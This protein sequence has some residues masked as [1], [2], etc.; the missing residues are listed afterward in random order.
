MTLLYTIRV[1]WIGL[2]IGLG[3]FLLSRAVVPGGT[4]TYQTNLL[5]DNY[6][7][8]PLAPKERLAG[9]AGAEQRTITGEPVYFSLFTPRSFRMAEITL[10][11]AGTAPLIELGIRRGGQTWNFE[12]QPVWHQGLEELIQSGEATLADGLVLWQRAKKYSTPAEFIAH[13]PA[14]DEIATYN[15]SLLAPFRLAGSA[16]TETERSLAV[17]LRGNYLI[18]TY[19]SGE[20]IAFS[21]TLRDLNQNKDRDDVRLT[22]YD[23]TGGVRASATLT[24]DDGQNKQVSQ[25]RLVRIESGPLPAGP[26]RL[27]FSANDDILT[28]QIQTRQSAV[29]FIN[30]IWLTENGR[31]SLSL[32]SDAVRLTAQTSAPGSRQTILFDGQPLALQETYRQ[33]SVS[34][35]DATRRAKKIVLGRD[36]VTLSVDGSLAFSEAELLNV[37]PRQFSATAFPARDQAAYVIARYE[38]QQPGRSQVTF[39]LDGAYR[40]EGKYSFMIAAPGVSPEKPL[41]IR[42]IRVRLVGPTLWHYIQ[43]K[44][45]L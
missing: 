30:H 36:D 11:Y 3:L 4:I 26:Y 41:E 9:Q 7:I 13:P 16:I 43:R 31:S 12:R 39:R 37:A 8:G 42:S 14:V 22:L 34:A 44:L 6:F 15:Y 25:P 28:D 20:P 38:S 33:V 1:I 21:F 19:S 29:S 18:Q 27:E 35:G 45:G 10:E 24:D 32:V 5:S 2:L 17:G 40:E 23:E